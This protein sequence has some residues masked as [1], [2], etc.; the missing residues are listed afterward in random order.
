MNWKVGDKVYYID[1]D[2]IV[3]EGQ[4]VRMHEEYCDIK[5]RYFTVSKHFKDMYKTNEEATEVAERDAE[6]I[7]AT[8]REQIKTKEDLINFIFDKCGN[9]EEYTNHEANEVGREKVLEMFGFVVE[10]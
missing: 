9:F 6:C 3:E 5:S 2:F 1:T 8:Y 7:K 4:I 10:E